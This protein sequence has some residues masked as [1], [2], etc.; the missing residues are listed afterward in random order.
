M[1]EYTVAPQDNFRRLESWL[2]NLLPD[3]PP[4]YI[5]KL[6]RSESARVNDAAA[7]PEL[8]LRTGD[9]IAL[10]ETGRLRELIA[11]SPPPL[12]ILYESDL[13]IVAGKPPGLPMH[14]A[15]EVDENLVD[16]G[17]AF[18]SRKGNPVRL[19]PVNRLDRGTS[20]AV[21][22]AKSPTA[23]AIFGKIVQEGGLDKLYLAVVA[24]NLHKGEGVIDTPLDGKEALTRY[25]SLASS[26]GLS[27]VALFPE[28]GR[29]HQL[30]QHLALLGHPVVGDRRYGG[31]VMPD[32]PGHALH[33]FRTIFPDPETKE[34][35]VIL[36][37]LPLAFLNLAARA[38]RS[39]PEQVLDV[40]SSFV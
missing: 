37:P 5:R 36:A 34:K 39:T 9:G 31:K 12:D 8:T 24:G 26:S 23:A 1:L 30:R 7:A 21:I 35:I 33:S 16:T 18:L 29:M 15:A 20:G 13:V 38:A 2:R 22:L 14:H 17:E 27:L 32:L 28:T 11:A 40:L 3:A 19:R 25:R 10:K 6:V 4:A